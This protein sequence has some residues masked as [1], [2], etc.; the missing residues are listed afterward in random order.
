LPRSA[1]AHVKIFGPL[2]RQIGHGKNERDDQRCLR[3]DIAAYPIENRLG[4][5][6]SAFIIGESVQ[7]DH[8]RQT[9]EQVFDK[10]DF[11]CVSGSYES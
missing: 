8:R 11:A 5:Q 4:L 9:I 3:V 10:T 2:L 6:H 7:A 1:R